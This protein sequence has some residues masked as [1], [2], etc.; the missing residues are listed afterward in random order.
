MLTAGKIKT[1]NNHG[2]KTFIMTS[3]QECSLFD[4]RQ[5]LSTVVSFASL[6]APDKLQSSFG[7]F[8][9]DGARQPCKPFLYMRVRIECDVSEDFPQVPGKRRIRNAA[10]GNGV[11]RSPLKKY[12]Y[13]T[14]IM[15]MAHYGFAR[16]PYLVPNGYAVGFKQLD[17]IDAWKLWWNTLPGGPWIRDI[18]LQLENHRTTRRVAKALLLECRPFR[19]VADG[20]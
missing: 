16:F 5:Q 17:S 10:I 1:N 20:A 11:Y 7:E 12:S 14:V 6:S 9:P 18:I 19:I 8:D 2:A 3:A 15:R 4:H 13:R